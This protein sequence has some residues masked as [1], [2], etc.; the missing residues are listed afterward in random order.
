ME[1]LEN[2]RRSAGSSPGGE[3]ADALDGETALSQNPAEAEARGAVVASPFHSERVRDEIDL[4]NARPESL[5]R[6]AAL[7]AGRGEEVAIPPDLGEAAAAQQDLEPPYSTVARVSVE[8]GEGSRHQQESPSDGSKPTRGAT[9]LSF[10]GGA[11][12]MNSEVDPHVTAAQEPD[13][14]E[15]L[16]DAP[17]GFQQEDQTARMAGLVELLIAQ[18]RMLQRKLDGRDPGSS[19]RSLQTAVEE[20]VQ[21]DPSP[22]S[23]R[24]HDVRKWSR[25]RVRSHAAGNLGYPVSP[26]GTVIRPPPGPPPGTPPAPMAGFAPH[27][28]AG[29]HP[30][31]PVA[32][33]ERPEEP[34]KYISELPKLGQP[35][36]KTSA[37]MAG[38]WLAQVRQVLLGLSPTAPDWWGA[39]EAAATNQYNRWLMSEPIDRLALDPGVIR[40]NFDR[41]RYQRVESRAVSLI[42]ASIP[43]NLRDE[44]VS[45]RWLSSEALIFR[46]QCVYQPGGASERSML[47]SF[48]VAPDAMKQLS[49]ACTILRKW[50]Q[51]ILRIQELRASLPD[52]S[53]LL[54]GIDQAAADLLTEHPAIAFRVNSFR[55]RVSIDHNP[56]VGTVCQLVRLLQAEFEAAALTAGESAEKK[57]K[58]V[59]HPSRPSPEVTVENGSPTVAEQ[60]AYQ[61]L[62]DYEDL[63][64][65][66]AK[67]EAEAS[68]L[69]KALGASIQD[70]QGWL[71]DTLTRGKL[72]P[73]ARLAWLR[74]VFSKVA[75]D[76]LV[77]ASGIC[78]THASRW[79]RRWRRSMERA[80]CVMVRLGLKARGDFQVAGPVQVVSCST[81]RETDICEDS[82]FASLLELAEQ[83]RIGGFVGAF[84]DQDGKGIIR[85]LRLSLL[86]AVASASDRMFNASCPV[87]FAVTQSA[88][89]ARDLGTLETPSFWD[90]SEVRSWV[91]LNDGYQARFDKGSFGANVIGPSVMLTNS[92]FLWEEL[93]EVLSEGLAPNV[94]RF[95]W[96]R[97]RANAQPVW[98]PGMWNSVRTALEDWAK[99]PETFSPREV[100]DRQQFLLGK[101]QTYAEHAALDHFPWRKGCAICW[102]GAARQRK[103][104]RQED[105]SM[106]TLSC[107]IAGPFRRGVDLEQA[108][109]YFIVGAI[110]IPALE[111]DQDPIEG[112]I[113]EEADR[114]FD[115]GLEVPGEV[116]EVPRG[117]GFRAPFPTKDLRLDG[118]QGSD[119]AEELDPEPPSPS[120]S[121][122]GI[123]DAG[124]LRENLEDPV[125][126]PPPLPPPLE[127]PRTAD[128]PESQC[129]GKETPSHPKMPHKTLILAQPIVSRTEA[130]ALQGL[131]AMFAQCRSAGIP[132]YRMLSDRAVELRGART[133]QWLLAQGVEPYLTAGEDSAANGRAESAI[134]CPQLRLLPFG[135]R[136]EARDRSWR[137]P[138]Q[139]WSPRT[140]LLV[141]NTVHL[142][143][144]SEP[145]GPDHAEVVEDGDGVVDRW[146]Q[147]RAQFTYEEGEVDFSQHVDE[148]VWDR[149]RIPNVGEDVP[150]QQFLPVALYLD[151][152]RDWTEDNEVVFVDQDGDIDPTVI[153]RV[154]ESEVVR[155]R[156]GG[157]VWAFTITS[158]LHGY[159]PEDNP[160][161]I[162]IRVTQALHVIAEHENRGRGLQPPGGVEPQGPRIAAIAVQQSEH[163]GPGEVALLKAPVNSTRQGAHHERQ[164]P[165]GRPPNAPRF[166]QSKPGAT[167][168]VLDTAYELELTSSSDVG[169]TPRETKLVCSRP[170]ELSDQWE[171]FTIRVR[172][173]IARE[174][175]TDETCLQLLS[176][177]PWPSSKTRVRKVKDESQESSIYAT[178]GV[179]AYGGVVG[180]SVLTQ[181]CPEFCVYV[182]RFLKLRLPSQSTWAALTITR[183]VATRMHKDGSN[184]EG[185]QVEPWEGT[186][187]SII[188]Y[189]PRGFFDHAAGLKPE[190][191]QAGFPTP[192]ARIPS[193]NGNPPDGI[194]NG[195]ISKDPNPGSQLEGPTARLS[196]WRTSPGDQPDGGEANPQWEVARD[197]VPLSP[198]ERES[199]CQQH[200]LL[201]IEL[202]FLEALLPSQ[203]QYPSGA[204][205]ITDTWA[206]IEGWM[207]ELE[208]ILWKEPSWDSSLDGVRR[209]CAISA[210]VG[211]SDGI[212]RACAL[213]APV[214]STE[215]VHPRVIHEAALGDEPE[216]PLE[217]LHTRTI[218]LEEVRATLAE[219]KEAIQA[220]V[221]SLF[222]KGAV[223]AITP[224]TVQS[225]VREGHP[226]QVLPGKGVFTRKKGYGKRKV[227]GVVCGNHLAPDS[228]PEH[229]SRAQ[230]RADL[231]AGGCESVTVR[232]LLRKAAASK[233]RVGS[234]DVST[235]FLNAPLNPERPHYIV[236]RP[237]KVFIDAGVVPESQL[238]HVQKALYGLASSPADWQ[239]HRNERMSK[240]SWMFE[241]ET[242]RFR[243]SKS[244]PNLWKVVN[245]VGAVHALAAWYVDDLL[246]AGPEGLLRSALECVQ[247]EWKTSLPEFAHECGNEPLKFCGF[248]I[249]QDTGF[250]IHLN[251]ASYIRELVDR[252]A[253]E[254]TAV[255]PCPSN[256][257]LGSEEHV[258]EN[259]DAL[260]RA[261]GLT[262]EVLWLATRSRPDIGYAVSR[263]ASA[264]TRNPEA[265]VADGMH[266]LKSFHAMTLL[267]GG[268][269]IAWDCGKQPLVTLSSTDIQEDDVSRVLYGDSLT[270]VNLVRSP[271]GSWRNRYQGQSPVAVVVD[272]TFR[273]SMFPGVFEG[274]EKG[275]YFASAVHE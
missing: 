122:L 187:W 270:G 43:Q 236:V 183:N 137:M 29:Y 3:A 106:F 80:T 226:V 168:G 37:V 203:V 48:V 99:G 257:A 191:E 166:G 221:T 87:F 67:I 177:A 197:V 121:E 119:L 113:D 35:D 242:Y 15:L 69:A 179:Y 155:I 154:V 229:S 70:P 185:H 163:V 186:R 195:K 141:T 23:F 227:R 142:T 76:D 82:V 89:G 85:F 216:E 83:G 249:F 71:K 18:N 12:P 173:A 104:P 194:R 232:A 58:L 184:A 128:N 90:S 156:G 140:E 22:Y 4:L 54:R 172:A 267:W 205:A 132:V 151:R 42:L 51:W 115:P 264:V 214:Q 174:D 210:P 237:P 108:P 61:L 13:E 188:A 269:A 10:S 165:V 181:M 153:A 45:N 262:G 164:L 143:P 148:G 206:R 170:R 126:D 105:K 109:A 138:D 263:M 56:T 241:G 133:K 50:Q 233:W 57:A 158:L 94:T 66:R 139:Q 147:M 92:W 261:Q 223:V 199:L 38:N 26:G 176:E 157:E 124:E 204:S 101:V 24:R 79:N 53:L 145:T 224:Q 118:Y 222:E 196:S 271:G 40:A 198:E 125:E 220:E 202:E 68:V 258:P 98:P 207:S 34:A 144:D 64:C 30:S 231:Y 244:E 235:A 160:V 240:M 273:W 28:G 97:L 91:E 159:P 250:N 127:S 20:F 167:C 193:D 201:S 95:G 36:L 252:H 93:H 6:D 52:A 130:A 107:D 136:V 230:Q 213:S 131:Q 238:W 182:N 46:I 239:S 255:A 161:V 171:Q 9:V 77:S 8:E 25:G 274:R 2:R 1:T 123:D 217:F 100:A 44:A 268:G 19:G 253:V 175:F 110:A 192:G 117:R 11:P 111:E 243:Q 260:R 189:T 266:L 21:A 116:V 75:D 200:A 88:V 275:G 169:L 78:S 149:F 72:G 178:F 219:W 41:I 245:S 102:R 246:A 112:C 234:L 7:V 215:T 63:Q 259:A 16:L 180:M 33:P 114:I 209:A 32:A 14:P 134:G 65:K 150:V 265:V 228:N 17:A 212:H 146:N 84:E 129:V 74:S 96:D 31:T 27:V 218:A 162:L 39:V 248:E 135:A 211:P 120:F 62:K 190:L 49:Q 73:E 47:L 247:K 256:S 225:W 103:H 254:G 59:I 55:H 5:D 251:Q 81:E 60:D 272:G 86:H 152:N 208:E